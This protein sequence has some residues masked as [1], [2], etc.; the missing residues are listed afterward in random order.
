MKS[1]CRPSFSL[2]LTAL[3]KIISQTECKVSFEGM[4]SEDQVILEILTGRIFECC[5]TKEKTKQK[6]RTDGSKGE[7]KWLAS[8]LCGGGEWKWEQSE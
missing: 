2:F 3:K 8:Q 5:E 7:R 4:S 1:H 6:H